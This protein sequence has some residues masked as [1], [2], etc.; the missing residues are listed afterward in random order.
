MVGWEKAGIYVPFP[1]VTWPSRGYPADDSEQMRLGC[2]WDD[3]D[4]GIS[5]GSGISQAI[6]PAW[7]G[8]GERDPSESRSASAS[9][10]ARR[11]VGLS[12]ARG[13]CALRI[14]KLCA[15]PVDNKQFLGMNL[16]WGA[17]KHC[18]PGRKVAPHR[19][20]KSRHAGATKSSRLRGVGPIAQPTARILSM[21]CKQLRGRA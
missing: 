12:R 4:G 15:L 13:A 9:R 3:L 16:L 19:G 11:H 18:S 5:G 6:Y 7:P 21:A 2:V 10:S 17:S 20:T 1:W 8:A 14:A